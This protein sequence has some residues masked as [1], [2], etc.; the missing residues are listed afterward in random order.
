MNKQIIWNIVNSLLAGGLVFFGAC[1][2]GE[3][4]T[5]SI[6]ASLFAAGVVAITKFKEFWSK[7][8]GTYNNL[9]SFVN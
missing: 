2:T 9:F 4:T 6:L 5:N 8:E 1:S 7:Q 3:I